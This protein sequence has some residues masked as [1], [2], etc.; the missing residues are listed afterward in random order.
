MRSP[1]PEKS[2]S[3]PIDYDAA[4]DVFITIF[5]GATLEQVYE[6]AV[7]AARNAE[8]L[9]FA[10]EAQALQQTAAVLRRRLN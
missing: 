1:K 2:A 6:E 7:S 4:A 10:R 8:A 5:P 3:K 9:G